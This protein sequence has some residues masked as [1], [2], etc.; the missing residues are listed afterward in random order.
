MLLPIS[1]GI[2]ATKLGLCDL[3]SLFQLCGGLELLGAVLKLYFSVCLLEQLVAPPVLP[4][5]PQRR[6]LL[7]QVCIGKRLITLWKA[8]GRG[9]Q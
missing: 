6:F 7:F 5:V 8:R 9:C 2:E 4:S 1:E 3:A